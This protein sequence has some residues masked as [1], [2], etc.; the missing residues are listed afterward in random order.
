MIGGCLGEKC[1]SS[2]GMSIRSTSDILPEWKDIRN[3]YTPPRW[4]NM[5]SIADIT[6]LDEMALEINKIL[7]RRKI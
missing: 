6:K 2:R 4:D 1:V 7:T 5:R 3:S